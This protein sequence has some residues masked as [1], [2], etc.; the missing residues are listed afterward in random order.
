M[1]KGSYAEFLLKIGFLSTETM[2]GF[3]LPLPNS[4]FRCIEGARQALLKFKQGLIDDFD[5][6]SSW[7]SREDCCTWK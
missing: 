4:E 5:L 3:G 2:I 6:L 1:M 7:G